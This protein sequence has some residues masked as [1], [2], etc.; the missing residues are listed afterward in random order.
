MYS[1]ACLLIF[2]RKGL[3]VLFLFFFVPTYNADKVG[4]KAKG[5]DVS[6][7]TGNLLNAERGISWVLAATSGRRKDPHKDQ[8]NSGDKM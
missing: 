5:Q 8:N 7:A 4:E 1:E 2:W 6:V 3:Q